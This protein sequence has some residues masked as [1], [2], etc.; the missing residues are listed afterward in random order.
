MRPL[1][2]GP[3][4]Q[5]GHRSL[6]KHSNACR[7]CCRLKETS[8]D[9]PTGSVKPAEEWLRSSAEAMPCATKSLL[10]PSSSSPRHAHCNSDFLNNILSGK[11]AFTSCP[12]L[13]T[14]PSRNSA[15]VARVLFF[16]ELLWFHKVSGVVSTQTTQASNKHLVWRQ[17][18]CC[19]CND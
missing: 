13:S 3:L 17:Q 10:S 9:P 11:K 14:F 4:T 7:A 12:F 18:S 6:I 2:L 8:T 15:A 5:G 16:K 19:P 1:R